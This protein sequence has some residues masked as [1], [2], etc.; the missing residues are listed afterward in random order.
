LI[1]VFS[2][3][4]RQ[5]KFVN[6]ELHS[7]VFK[8]EAPRCDCGV[9]YRALESGRNRSLVFFCDSFNVSYKIQEFMPSLESIPLAR[10]V[11]TYWRADKTNLISYNIDSTIIYFRH[12]DLTM[13]TI[14]WRRDSC[15]F[16]M[17]QYRIQ[18]SI[19]TNYDEQF[20][21]IIA[22]YQLEGTD[23]V[24][25]P[26][27]L[28]YLDQ[29][30]FEM[31]V[32]EQLLGFLPP[33]AYSVSNY[34]LRDGGNKRIL[35]FKNDSIIASYISISDEIDEPK[36]PLVSRIKDLGKFAEVD[37]VFYNEDSSI[38]YV[39]DSE[40]SFKAVSYRLDT[41]DY[42]IVVYKF[43]PNKISDYDRQFDSIIDYFGLRE[44]Y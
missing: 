1:V 27:S 13:R 7:L 30:K 23:T 40:G 38:V 34:T 39:Q 2:C 31:K 28:Y 10:S 12:S 17:G 22:A 8:F 6:S 35:G 29:N 32:K 5:E 20:D 36:K 18:S 15:N 11:M 16:I 26:E 3:T 4:H 9:N 33:R 37:M 24:Y 21:E 42:I 25:E 41:T 19:R 43:Y 14:A 44:Y